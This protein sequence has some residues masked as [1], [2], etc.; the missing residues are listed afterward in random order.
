MH[1]RFECSSEERV[2]AG[3]AGMFVYFQQLLG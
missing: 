1:G 2:K 3:Q